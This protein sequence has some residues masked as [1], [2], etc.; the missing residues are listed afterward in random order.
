MK[1]WW[2]KLARYALPEWRGLLLIGVLMLLGVAAGLLAPWPLK[3]IVDNVLHGEAVP[4]RLIWIQNLPGA[5]SPTGL[6]AWLAAA[7][8]GLFLVRRMVSILQAYTQAGTGSRMVYGLA[9]DLFLHL[10]TRSLRFHQQHHTGDL[11][12]RV[13]ADTSCVRELVMHVYLPLLTSGVT[14]LSMFSVMWQI[15]QSLALFAIGLVLPLVLVVRFFAG[16]MTDRKYQE[17]ELQ[18]EISSLAE[19]TLTAIPIV[20]AFGR[21]EREDDR[22]RHIARRSLQAS[23]KSEFSQHQFRVSTGT[24]SAIGTAVVMVVGG[25]SVLEGRLSIGSLLV[26]V[27]YF[28]ALYS[29]IETLAYLSEGF[30]SAA[31]GARRVFEIF[32]ADDPTVS[33][34]PDARAFVRDQRSSGIAL[35]FENV[36]FGYEPGRP[37]LHEISLHVRSGET[38]ALVGATGAGK[39]TLVSLIPRLFD[40]WQGAVLFD[41]INI[42]Q[43]QVSSVRENVAMVLQE[44][45]LL[46]LSI[47]ENIAYARPNAAR[48]EIVAAAVAAKADAFIDRLPR[49]YDTVIGERGATLSGGEKQ[50]LSIARALLKDAP[51]LILDEPTA[52]LDARTEASLVEAIENLMR[53]RTTIVIAHRLS[54]IRRAERIV[55]MQNG[56]FVEQGTHDNLLSIDGYYKRLQQSAHPAQ[57]SLTMSALI[58]GISQHD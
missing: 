2:L 22:F 54:T 50:R 44:P 34:A 46:P 32:S 9:A 7:T 45:F 48:N 15:S 53:E 8:V 4:T 43:L 12:R 41:D 19:Q 29:P 23:L 13:T 39:S 1:Y 3:L 37:V 33:D 18:G 14:V 24:V 25:I 58:G 5:A 36:V 40:P 49:G 30:A 51:I 20:Q 55:V 31:A 35:R 11:I 28:A 56:Q 27:S 42:R 26:L 17:W 16:S 57:T 52:A 6:L 38:V 47:A 21:E 10:Q